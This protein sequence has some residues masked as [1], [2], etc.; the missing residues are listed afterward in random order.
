MGRLPS[1]SSL[2]TAIMLLEC[3]RM[4]SLRLVF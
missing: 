3:L 2:L 4:P 1:A